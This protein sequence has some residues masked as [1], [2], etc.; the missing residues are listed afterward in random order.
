MKL[1]GTPLALQPTDAIRNA[2][3]HKTIGAVSRVDVSAI[4]DGHVLA[5][6]LEWED[7]T[8]NRQPGDNT[9]FPDAAAVL[10]PSVP[11]A[12]LVTMGAAAF[13]VNAWYWRADRETEVRHV[14]AEG[15]GTSRTVA[16]EASQASALWKGA[17]WRVVITRALQVQSLDP[18]AQLRPGE[19]TGFAVAIWDGAHGERGGI[20]AY[21]GPEWQ[22]LQLEAPKTARR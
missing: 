16:I 5:V 9:D 21:T 2:W 13:A 17:R 11:R 4:H 14:V 18:L 20:K 7:P 15:I 1:E 3:M 19:S 22:P 10:F 6:R 8:E 12:P